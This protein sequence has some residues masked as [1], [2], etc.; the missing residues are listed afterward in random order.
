MQWAI[1]ATFIY[2]ILIAEDFLK[3][4]GLQVTIS[5]LLYS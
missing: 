3:I 5:N 1:L 4:E 2:D